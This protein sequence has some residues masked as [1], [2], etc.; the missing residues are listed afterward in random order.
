LRAEWIASVH[1]NL[2]SG[3]FGVNK[4]EQGPEAYHWP[5][6]RKDIEVYAHKCDSCQKIK[7]LRQR[8]FGA[9]H[10]TYRSVAGRVV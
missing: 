4:G 1:S 8:A 9:L 3:H 10:W 6:L 2:Y 5:E 7:P